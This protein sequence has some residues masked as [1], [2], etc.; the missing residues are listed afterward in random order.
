MN[1]PVG[2]ADRKAS[3]QKGARQSPC[4]ARAPRL[5]AAAGQR[6]RTAQTKNTPPTA[7]TS[8][9]RGA[10]DQ[11]AR[12]GLPWRPP[13]LYPP[14]GPTPCRS[15]RGNP[16]PTPRQSRTAQTRRRRKLRRE[17]SP[18]QFEPKGSG[19]RRPPSDRR[20]AVVA[21][22]PRPSHIRTKRP[23]RRLPPTR[24]VVAKGE[25]L[26]EPAVQASL[27]PPR[28]R[29]RRPGR[30]MPPTRAVV[31]KGEL[32]EQAAQAS[33]S[34]LRV[35][36]PNAQAAACPLQGP[37]SPERSPLRAKQPERRLMA[38]PSQ[39]TAPRDRR[40]REAAN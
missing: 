37:S 23:G 3:P 34:S 24:A 33:R 21:A 30:R 16:R 11:G 10:G 15:P 40:R 17:L 26:R 22:R 20:G 25:E 19:R 28:I 6:P 18:P 9:C 32:Q 12:G 4:L 5:A 2:N 7:F 36:G 8:S 38:A 39:A 1:L 27:R 14:E 13:T 29:A 31:A 35:F